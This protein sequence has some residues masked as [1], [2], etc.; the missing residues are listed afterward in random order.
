MLPPDHLHFW[1]L[2]ARTQAWFHCGDSRTEGGAVHG[3]G[4]RFQASKLRCKGKGTLRVSAY[5]YPAPFG[6]VFLLG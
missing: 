3:C 6:F 2:T 1:W 5:K 4:G